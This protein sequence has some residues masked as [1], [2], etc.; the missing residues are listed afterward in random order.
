VCGDGFLEID[1]ADDA[2]ARSVD[3]TVTGHVTEVPEMDCCGVV[4]W[5]NGGL[6]ELW[7]GRMAP[8]HGGLT[9]CDLA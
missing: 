9:A 3:P 2:A 4:G 1:L 8:F 7:I 6:P 5:K